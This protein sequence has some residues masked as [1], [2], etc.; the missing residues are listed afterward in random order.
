MVKQLFFILFYITQSHV[1][2][3]QSQQAINKLIIPAIE[4]GWMEVYEGEYISKHLLQ[5][6]WPVVAEEAWAIDGVREEVIVKVIQH[7]RWGGWCSWGR[8]SLT[9]ESK[10]ISWNVAGVGDFGPSAATNLEG[11]EGGRTGLITRVKGLNWGIVA[12]RDAGEVGVDYLGGYYQSRLGEGVNFIIGDHRVHWGSGS[13]VFRY[14][15]FQSM[16]APHNLGQ[17]SRD[18]SGV[19]TG[20]GTPSRRGFAV[21]KT[22]KNWWIYTSFDTKNRE[23]VIDTTTGEITSI[24]SSGLHR[25]EVERSR[26]EV[27]QSRLAWSV[28]HKGEQTMLGVLGE[29]GPGNVVG[30]LVRREKNALS[31]ESEISIFK[32]GVS[33]KNRAVLAS[34]KNIFVFAS[35]DKHN[36]KHPYR[37]YGEQSNS[38]SSWVGGGGFFIIENNKK[39]VVKYEMKHGE[40]NFRSTLSWDS[41]LEIGGELQTRIQIKGA[42]DGAVELLARLKWDL[43]F[44]KFTGELI[45]SGNDFASIGRAFR[46][47]IK[48]ER[49]LTVAVMNGGDDMLGRLCQLLPTARGYRLFSVGDS[50]SRAIITWEVIVDRLVISFEKVWPKSTVHEGEL[51]SQRISIRF[52]G[53]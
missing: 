2:L 9:P 3:S 51:S 10:A 21:S 6:G 47:D 28:F 5:Y 20:D 8:E 32:G 46:V 18:F 41:E 1:F 7:D 17:T 35:I 42:Y 25:T 16:R 15:P 27:R 43:P 48:N 33:I 38:D 53:R 22:N 11:F 30:L 26:L 50:T 13:T 52:E 19:N 29:V 45:K 39:L 37:M 24:Y 4:D 34:G 40:L 31:Y 36:L 49:T 12:E 44:V 23:C 14:D